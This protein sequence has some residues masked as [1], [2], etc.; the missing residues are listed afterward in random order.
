MSYLKRENGNK[1]YYEDTGSGD[2]AVVLIHGWG[3]N[4]RAWDKTVPALTEA[5]Y[6]VVALDH[7][8][9]GQSDAAF[10]EISA[11]SIASD[12]VALTHYLELKKVVLNGWSLGGAVAVIAAAELKNYCTGLVL[13]CAASPAFV[14]QDGYPHGGDMEDLENIVGALQADRAST[15]PNLAVGCFAENPPQEQVEAMTELFRQSDPACNASLIALGELDQRDALGAL[16]QPI[17]V[18]VGAK[19]TLVDPNVPRSVQEFHA[20]TTT[21]EFEASGHTPFWEET[22]KYNAEIVGFANAQL[23]A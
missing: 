9:C 23:S 10:E 15:L 22:N 5:G 3:A 4:L 19:D 2:T 21:V 18:I 12:V 14:K 20:N 7:R 13:T 11:A 6:R 8:A 16:S 17:L 1:I